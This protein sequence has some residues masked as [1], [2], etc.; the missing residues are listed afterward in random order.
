MLRPR[1]IGHACG[2]PARRQ[3]E[4]P[5]LRQFWRKAQGG[6]EPESHG[7]LIGLFQFGHAA[8][9]PEAVE[10]SAMPTGSSTA[11]MPK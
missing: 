11:T 6:K 10:G 9:F 7:R 3:I 5:V 2:R 8:H 4:K 1:H